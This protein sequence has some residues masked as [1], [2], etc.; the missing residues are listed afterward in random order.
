MTIPFLEYHTDCRIGN[1]W[2][3]PI[4]LETRQPTAWNSQ[5]GY[6][7]RFVDKE[8]DASLYCSQLSWKIGTHVNVDLDSNSPIYLLWAAAMYG[9]WITPVILPAV[10]PDEVMLSGKLNPVTSGWNP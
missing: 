4:T 10:A 8:T 3:Y 9:A 7:Y 1:F 5:P 2:F 6:N